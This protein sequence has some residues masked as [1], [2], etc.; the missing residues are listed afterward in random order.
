MNIIA[1]E[2][3]GNLNVTIIDAKDLPIRDFMGTSDPYC[4]LY[5]GGHKVKTPTIKNSL[6][7]K[8]D[9]SVIFHCSSKDNLIIECW[10]WDRFTRN[11]FIGQTQLPIS[12][13]KP[14]VARDI[15]LALGPRAGKKD[16]NVKGSI[17]LSL[18]FTVGEKPGKSEV[19]P[20]SKF[21]FFKKDKL[22]YSPP[23]AVDTKGQA[24]SAGFLDL[25]VIEAKGL[26]AKDLNGKSDPFT[27]ISFNEKTYRTKVITKTLDPV[28]NQKC[29]FAVAVEEKGYSIFL[30]V[31]DK[32]RLSAN[33][34]IGSAKIDLPTISDGA[35]HDIWVDLEGPGEAKAKAGKM[36][37]TAQYYTQQEI[38]RQFW[39]RMATI[40]DTDNSSRLSRLEI[41]ALIQSLGS[42]LDDKEIWDIFRKEK[43][44]GAD[45]YD[46]TISID[47]IPAIMTDVTSKNLIQ[48][49]RDPITKSVLPADNV[50]KIE[51]LG[52]SLIEDPDNLSDMVVGG[53]LTEHEASRNWLQKAW[54]SFLGEKANY[55]NSVLSTGHILIHE[56]KT[57]Q[58]V[59]E[60]IPPYIKV[61]LRAMYALKFGRK[62]VENTKVR[63]FLH[64]MTVKQGKAYDN[65]KSVKEIPHFIEYHHL[66]MEEALDT[67]YETFNQFFYRKLKPGA[68][69][70]DNPTEP[71][72][73][74][75]PADCRCLVFES[76]DNAR[77]FWVKGEQFSIQS[78]LKND[79]LAKEFDGCS[80]S[81]CRL[82]PQDYHRFHFPVDCTVGPSY[83]LPGAFFTVNPLAIRENID[84]F[85]EN[86]R[87]VTQLMTEQ[88]D[89]VI[90]VAVGATLV[91]SIRLTSK[92]GEKHKKG[93]EHGYF[94]FGGSTCIVIF[95]KGVI[96]FD[97]DLLRN[98]CEENDHAFPIE[99]LMK[100]G[101]SLGRR[102]K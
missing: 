100:M 90:I 42:D 31:Y 84:V 16:P 97:A 40:Y 29:G 95:K 73:A 69:I 46:T 81:I 72:V 86:R 30:S 93:D 52:I 45:D 60:K 37:V 8:W 63:N 41:C 88:L 91:G 58:L 61:S 94:A 24:P 18:T 53:F 38:Q 12:S 70:I 7:P 36:H 34:F 62:A 51:T 50:K 89:K 47:D 99:T 83:E 6:N 79:E 49:T 66:P 76:F 67:K 96:K 48:W 98:S 19:Q 26:T 75:S 102:A 82:A 80:F 1:P 33:D 43:N 74:T 3:H 2:R 77:K 21:K 65:P 9:F 39:I 4:I 56:R 22:D 25:R 20:Q 57:G 23:Q 68:R 44:L 35:Q 32:D 64:N 59:E 13:L 78:L 15:T 85:T 28:W 92:E 27:I 54:G 14:D 5:L 55:K 87:T 17:H 101:Y 71:D 11:D 10:D